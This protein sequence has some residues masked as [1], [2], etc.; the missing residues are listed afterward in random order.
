MSVFRIYVEKKD[1]YSVEAQGLYNDLKASLHLDGLKGVRVLNR[2]DVEGVSEEVFHMAAV[3]IF[4][5]PAV[6]VTYLE[7]PALNAGQRIF[8]RE[9]LPGQFDQRA[10]SCSQCIQLATQGERPAVKSAQIYILDGVLSDEQF[11]AVKHYLINPVESREASLEPYDT[12]D[13]KYELPSDVAVLEGF[14]ELDRQGLADFIKEYGLAMD[15]DDIAFCQSYFKEKE[16]RDPTITEIRM[17]DTYW[18]D[19]CRHTTF[20]TIIDQV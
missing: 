8:A 15:L 12:L 19:H 13:T 1:K 6:D 3:N 18:S 11:A 17:I 14:L 4:S 7:L 10:D 16:Q 5:E 9:Y 2:Y 20:S